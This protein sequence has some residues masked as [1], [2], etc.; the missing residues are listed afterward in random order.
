MFQ[1]MLAVGSGGGGAS[2]FT[3]EFSSTAP[4]GAQAFLAIPTSSI[5]HFTAT[6]NSS[7][8]PYADD[9]RF[10]C[11]YA[12]SIPKSDVPFS[13]LI[14]QVQLSAADFDVNDTYAYVVACAVPNAYIAGRVYDITVTLK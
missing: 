12:N 7:L 6:Y 3:F 5:S 4:S 13:S 2:T 10:I 14:N 11:G 8:S 9:S 1:G